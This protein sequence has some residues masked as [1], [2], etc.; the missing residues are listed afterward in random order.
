MRPQSPL[1]CLRGAKSGAAGP[2]EAT[3]LRYTRPT[4]WTYVPPKL[5]ER[6]IRKLF[7]EVAEN[8][9]AVPGLIRSRRDGRRRP[10]RRVGSVTSEAPET[11]LPFAVRHR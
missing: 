10:A 6:A 8:Y 11:V 4:M 2:P 9:L 3:L 1:S 5:T 7:A